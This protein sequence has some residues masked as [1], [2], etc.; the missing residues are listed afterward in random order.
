MVF[1]EQ[2]QETYNSLLEKVLNLRTHFFFENDIPNIKKLSTADVG[3]SLGLWL[4]LNVFDL[5]IHWLH[6]LKNIF[7]DRV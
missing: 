6:F 2:Q 4:G 3:G 5:F 1:D 7:K